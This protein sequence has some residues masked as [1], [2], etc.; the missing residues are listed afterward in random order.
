MHRS[1]LDFIIEGKMEN[2]LKYKAAK[3]QHMY[4]LSTD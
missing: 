4:N 2:A 3:A 1:E